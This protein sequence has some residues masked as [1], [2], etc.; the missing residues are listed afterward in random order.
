V[1]AFTISAKVVG[2]LY[3]EELMRTALPFGAVLVWCRLLKFLHFSQPI[4]VLIIMIMAMLSDIALW[5]LVSFV[6]TAAFTVAFIATSQAPGGPLEVAIMPM[7]ALIGDYDVDEVTEWS[8]K[9]GQ[10]MIW[11]FIV[12]SNILLVNLLIAMMGDTYATIKE[13]SDAEWKIGRLRSVQESVRQMHPVPPPLNLPLTVMH[14]L[15]NLGGRDDKVKISDEAQKELNANWAVG[16]KLWEAKR[17]KDRVARTLLSK[18][19]KKRAE[20]AADR[21][22]EEGIDDRLKNVE[23]MIEGLYDL[24]KTTNAKTLATLEPAPLPMPTDKQH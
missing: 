6:F 20:E 21:S 19:T 3:S 15:Q 17:E 10:G 24:I 8:P 4:G 16:G 7:W 5:A 9:V 14:F 23:T 2:L 18:L 22:R 12:V 1:L 13:N 11:V